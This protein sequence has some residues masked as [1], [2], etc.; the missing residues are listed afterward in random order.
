MSKTAPTGEYLTVGSFMIRGKKNFLPPHPLI[1]GF[2]MLFRLD[3]SSLGSHL[4]ERRIRGDEEGINENEESGP[5]KEISD[6]DSEEE[7]PIEKHTPERSKE[8]STDHRK[9]ISG[10]LSLEV[11]SGNG[12]RSSEF[13]A[14][15]SDEVSVEE[16][17]NL[18]D[19]DDKKVAETALESVASVSPQL[20]DILD[21]ALELGAA[22]ISVK[23]YGRLAAQ[24][25]STEEHSREDERPMVREKPYIS[26]AERRKLKKGDSSS[27]AG[28]SVEHEKENVEDKSIEVSQPD[29]ND[30][31]MKQ[32]GGGKVSRGQRSKFKKLKE[33][34]AN[35][36]E[37]ERS[38]RMALLAVSTITCSITPVLYSLVCFCQRYH[39]YVS[40]A[41][42]YKGCQGCFIWSN[43]RHHPW[44]QP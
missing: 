44:D 42:Y 14:I 33:K 36:D 1:M 13:K 3:E 16:S 34:Y 7:V 35:Q 6:S 22:S 12:L 21:R 9:L 27:I 5:F 30:Q 40:M 25:N 15:D 29:K 43:Q 17:T 39:C 2:G 10:G 18:K 8:S 37:E 26:K 4:N 41:D 20:E 31:N 11:G 28:E 32:G 19:F 23:D 24:V 38:I